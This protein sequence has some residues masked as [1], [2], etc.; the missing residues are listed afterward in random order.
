[1]HS[2]CPLPLLVYRF[3]ILLLEVVSG[4]LPGWHEAAKCH[5]RSHAKVIGAW[6]R[7][8]FF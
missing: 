3:G 8:N 6:R 4:Q 7:F 1:L 5:G 2:H